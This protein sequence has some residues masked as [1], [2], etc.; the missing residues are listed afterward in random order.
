MRKSQNGVPDELELELLDEL[1]LEELL[2]E[3]ELDELEL[4]L[5]EELEL[6]LDGTIQQLQSPLGPCH[7]I[8]LHRC[9]K[10]LE[11]RNT[12]HPA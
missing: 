11:W 1:E 7:P 9:C 3:L 2:E 6:E 4:L 5:L 10:V 12:Y 8:I